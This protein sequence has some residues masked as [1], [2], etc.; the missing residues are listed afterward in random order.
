[1]FYIWQLQSILL[2]ISSEIAYEEH[3]SL[4]AALVHQK[5]LES[6]S[7]PE[8]NSM[9]KPYEQYVYLG[10][11]FDEPA[12]IKIVEDTQEN[13]FYIGPFKDRFFLFD[14]LDAMEI[15]TTED[16]N[17]YKLASHLAA[18]LNHH[19]FDTLYHALAIHEKAILVTADQRYFRKSKQRGSICLLP[20]FKFE[21]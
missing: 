17:L 7:H 14:L 20:E 16:G 3:E 13:R 8:F 9:I 11:N 5:K 1:M 12:Y 15:P 21:T 6:T 19:L 18:G 4:F 10:I 2:L